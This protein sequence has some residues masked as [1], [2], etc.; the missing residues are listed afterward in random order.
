MWT[1]DPNTYQ[2]PTIVFLEIYISR[3]RRFADSSFIWWL[4]PLSFFQSRESLDFYRCPSHF[5]TVIPFSHCPFSERERKMEKAVNR[6][7]VL[8]GHLQPSSS[9]SSSLSQSHESACFSVSCFWFILAY[10]VY[11]CCLTIA[12]YNQKW[13][14]LKG[15]KW[16]EELNLLFLPVIHCQNGFCSCEISLGGYELT[17]EALRSWYLPISITVK[18]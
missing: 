9:S 12:A 18:E 14:K 15:F 6:Q 17:M 5:R 1:C 7:K 4:G 11:V 2:T 8:L 3:G 13:V 16:I 10:L